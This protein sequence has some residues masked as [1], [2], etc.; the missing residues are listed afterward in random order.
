M[1]KFKFTKTGIKDMFVVEPTV[2]EDER[3]ISWKPIR[4]TTSGMQ[5]M[6]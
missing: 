5:D 6:T 3:D 2:F 1:G 4:K